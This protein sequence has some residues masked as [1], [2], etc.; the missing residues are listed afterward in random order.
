M[1]S[2]KGE[3]RRLIKQKGIKLNGE[4]VENEDVEVKL[5]KEAKLLQ[6]GKR[7]FIKVIGE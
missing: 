7:N 2:S 4:V 1:V 5:N 3:A 6:R